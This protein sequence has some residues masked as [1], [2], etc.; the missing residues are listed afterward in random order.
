MRKRDQ[1]GGGSEARISSFQDNTGYTYNQF[2][3]DDEGRLTSFTVTSTDTHSGTSTEKFTLDYFPSFIRTSEGRTYTLSDGRVT[4][5]EEQ[6]YRSNNYSQYDFTYD[7]DGQL[8]LVAE[9]QYNNGILL[10][11]SRTRIQWQNGNI[12][13]T[14]SGGETSSFV[15]T[16][17]PSNNFFP[18]EDLEASMP[19]IDG[20]DPYL[21]SKGYF[22][23]Y[24]RNVVKTCTVS[25]NDRSYTYTYNYKIDNKGNIIEV[26]EEDSYKS[27]SDRKYNCKY[28]WE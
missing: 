6:P 28:T 5:L 21:F 22:G 24:P 10:N 7:R 23:K 19:L 16:G 1:T 8:T 3:Y 26:E 27:G 20:V 13:S 18:M 25:G 15:Y 2:I 4:H 17:I 14:E 11:T 12:T 9:S